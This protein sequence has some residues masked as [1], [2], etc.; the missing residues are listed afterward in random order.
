MGVGLLVIWGIGSG[1]KEGVESVFL[2]DVVDLRVWRGLRGCCGSLA[3][4][5]GV[6][7]RSS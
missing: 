3:C 4:W 1:C 2:D 6:I 5:V 7:V